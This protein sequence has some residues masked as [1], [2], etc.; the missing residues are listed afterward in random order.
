MNASLRIAALALSVAGLTACAGSMEKSTYESPG[1]VGSY[2]V[3]TGYV[4]NIERLARKQG[5]NVTWVNMPVKRSHT[6][7]Q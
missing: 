3:D 5:A 6:E 4:S 7:Q 2:A 1:V